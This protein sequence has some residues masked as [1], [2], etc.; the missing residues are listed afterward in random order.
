MYSPASAKFVQNAAL[1]DSAFGTSG[2]FLSVSHSVNGSPA[3]QWQFFADS[4]AKTASYDQGT[5]AAFVGPAGVEIAF[6]QNG[7]LAVQRYGFDGAPR[8][9][10]QI[11]GPAS[12]SVLIGGATDVNGHTLIIWGAYGVQGVS[13]R[14]FA[15]DGTAETGAFPLSGWGQN[16]G[17]SSPLPKGGVAVGGLIGP[18]WRSIVAEASTSETDPGW[19]ADR[20]DGFT[21]VLGN[22]AMAFGSEIVS[23]E[24]TSCGTV[25]YGANETL[26]GIGVDGTALTTADGATVQV[27]PSFLR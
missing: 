4:G 24:G 22:R 6:V 2:G 1:G 27:Y 14:W 20:D 17:S 11:A 10:P 7:S 15:P 26:L 12:G 8:G 9:E 23:P 5:S 21:L 13:A 16:I 3:P 19:L 25:D 18:R